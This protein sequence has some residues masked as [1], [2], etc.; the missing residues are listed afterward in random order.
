LTT[1]KIKEQDVLSSIIEYLM[2]SNIPHVHVRNTGSI[3]NRNGNTFFAKPK[4]HQKGAP[5]IMG[6]CN[7]KAFAIEVK[8]ETGRIS[9]EQIDWLHKWENYGGGYFIIARNVESVQQFIEV[10]KTSEYHHL[11][12]G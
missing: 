6:A 2:R 5:D 11:K 4:F 3:I 12:H 8:S 10:L 7:G 1:L 9:E